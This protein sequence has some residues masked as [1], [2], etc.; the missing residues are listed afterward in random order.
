MQSTD[1]IPWRQYQHFKDCS[2][3]YS[4]VD[5]NWHVDVVCAPIF[6]PLNFIPIMKYWVQDNQCYIPTFC[7][8]IKFQILP[9]RLT[10][11]FHSLAVIYNQ[12]SQCILLLVVVSHSIFCSP[13]M[14][15]NPCS[16]SLHKCNVC[17]VRFLIL[18]YYRFG[19]LI[20]NHV[21]RLN[22]RTRFRAIAEASIP[23]SSFNLGET[24]SQQVDRELQPVR[25]RS[26]FCIIEGI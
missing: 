11:L 17:T 6:L 14:V 5:F 22:A 13:R 10:I 12:A 21:G 26:S 18:C 7:N 20:S 24:S 23:L 9:C 1:I 8:P 16:S 15:W 2:W 25:I 3:A 19:L 4:M